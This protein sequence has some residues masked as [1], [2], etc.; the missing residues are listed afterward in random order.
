[1]TKEMIFEIIGYVGSGLVVISMLMTS[2]VR[3]RIFNLIGSMIFAVYA[4]LIKSYPTAL[5][6]GFLVVINIVQL[7]KLGRK[8]GGN[9]EVQPVKQAEG[10][11]D[12]FLNRNWQDIQQY[13]PNVTPNLAKEAEGYA[14]FFENQA[15]GI[16]LGVRDGETFQILL[17]YTTPNFRDCSVGKFLYGELPSFGITTLTIRSTMPTHVQYME[18]MGFVRTGEET[19]TK[20]LTIQP[21][22]E[23]RSDS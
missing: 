23:D 10:F 13:F 9:Y 21:E 2:V 14:V 3:L 8:K 19:F 1:M 17:D 11:A 5:L 7:I 22:T 4:I 6:N 18:K 16:L 20:A 15:A 12:W